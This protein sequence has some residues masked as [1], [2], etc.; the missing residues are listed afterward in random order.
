MIALTGLGAGAVTANLA[1]CRRGGD[2]AVCLEG[3]RAGLARVLA[4][5]RAE[6]S[7]ALLY[8]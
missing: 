3:R 4:E 1:L 8:G 6:D 7:P 5:F 2:G